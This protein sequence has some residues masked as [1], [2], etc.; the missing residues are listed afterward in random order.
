M[1]GGWEGDGNGKD[2]DQTEEMQTWWPTVGHDGTDI[3]WWTTVNG[4]EGMQVERVLCKWGM[5]VGRKVY[6]VV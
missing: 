2:D 3:A 6:G 5:V 4:G 1:W